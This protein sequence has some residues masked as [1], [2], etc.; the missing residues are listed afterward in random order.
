MKISEVSACYFD[1]AFKKRCLLDYTLGSSIFQSS[2]K[3]FRTNEISISVAEDGKQ[4]VCKVQ[5]KAHTVFVK[6]PAIR[7]A[8]ED[9]QKKVT[10]IL[11]G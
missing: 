3:S 1:D 2:T 6:L 4:L 9:P 8:S 10:M 11:E 5:R 7:W